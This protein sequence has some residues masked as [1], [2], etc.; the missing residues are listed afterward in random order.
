M[1]VTFNSQ[2]R[3]LRELTALTLTAGWKVVQV[4]RAEGA[5]FGHIIAIPV[6]IPEES[7]TLLNICDDVSQEGMLILLYLFMYS[8]SNESCRCS[9][10]SKY[11]HRSV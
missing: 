9:I 5:L 11:Q 2:E 1:R 6:E 8:A 3:T 7:L 10:E 4:I